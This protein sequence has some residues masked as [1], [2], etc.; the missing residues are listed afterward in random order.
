VLQDAVLSDGPF[1]GLPLSLV[2]DWGGLDRGAAGCL[3]RNWRGRKGRGARLVEAVLVLA[4]ALLAEV[5]VEVK[6]LV[7]PARL[8]RTACA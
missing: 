3:A 6:L 4:A 1:G 5:D 8:L 7:I 2:V